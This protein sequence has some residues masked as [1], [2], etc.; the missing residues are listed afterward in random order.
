[1]SN[2][3]SQLVQW[4]AATPRISPGIDG[5]LFHFRDFFGRSS[6]RDGCEAYLVEQPEGVTAPTHFHPVNQYQVIFGSPGSRFQRAEV[7]AVFVHYADARVPYGPIETTDAPL[8]YYT[9]R[10]CANVGPESVSLMPDARALRNRDGRNRHFELP[11]EDR[12]ASGSTTWMIAPEDDGLAARIE[13]LDRGDECVIDAAGGGQY[14]LPLGA[15]VV[16]GRPVDEE[17]LAW[18]PA[19]GEA[20]RIAAAEDGVRLIVMTFPENVRP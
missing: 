9:L 15:I 1:M 11:D 6:G 20:L 18:I 4:S 2:V 5:R 16:N 13:H 8:R 19:Q 12:R 7:G 3:S 17:S 10:P 14:V